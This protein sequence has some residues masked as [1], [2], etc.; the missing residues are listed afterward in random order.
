MPKRE[1][2]PVLSQ[3]EKRTKG[4]PSFINLLLQPYNLFA[5]LS[6]VFVTLFLISTPPFQVPDQVTH[7]NR[8][9]KLGEGVVKKIASLLHNP[10]LAIRI[11]FATMNYFP[12]LLYRMTIGV[13]GYADTVLPLSCPYL[14]ALQSLNS[15]L[16]KSFTR[17]RRYRHVCRCICSALF[18]K[19]QAKRF[20]GNGCARAIPRAFIDLLHVRIPGVNSLQHKFVTQ[21]DSS[22]PIIRY[23]VPRFVRHTN[24]RF[25]QIL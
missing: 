2:T 17:S 7:F 5:I 8:V 24:D 10:F 9:F 22:F 23:F 21:Q 18:D 15:K 14:R 1:T 6:L 25:R 19:P 11:V 3:Q 16:P 13:L 20:C 12:G 4:E